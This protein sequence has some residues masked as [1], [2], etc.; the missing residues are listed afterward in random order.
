MA[1]PYACSDQRVVV[2]GGGDTAMDCVR[3]GRLIVHRDVARDLVSVFRRL[4]AARFPIRRMLP[5]DRYGASDYRS[6]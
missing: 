5:V 2:L 6:I 4:Y 1:R 3:T